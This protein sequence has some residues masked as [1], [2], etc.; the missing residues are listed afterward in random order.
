[1]NQ[2]E[3][4][5]ATR[6]QE[7]AQWYRVASLR[8]RVQA[9]ARLHRHRYR[10]ALWYVLEDRA[11]GQLHRFTP[12]ARLLIAAM[13]GRRSMDDLWRLGQTQL[14]DDA[15]TQDE[16]INLVA[17][18]HM[19][20]VLATDIPPDTLES[21]ERGATSARR[22][23]RS[24]W[25]NPMAI[26][27]PLWDPGA[28]LDHHAGLWRLLWGRAGALLW[29]LLVVPAVLLVPGAWPELTG[30]L[31]DRV[32]Q[33]N[34]LV[35]MA[36]LF[37]L[38]KILHEIGHATAVRAHGGEVHDMGVM[39]LVLMPIP[40]VDASAASAFRSRWSRACVGA[41]GMG[42][43]ILLAALAFFLWLLVEPGL[44]RAVCFNVMLVA[45]ISTLLFNGNPL[46]RFDAYYIVADLLELPN[47]A[48]R[49]ARY[50]GYLAERYLLRNRRA[51]A[52]VESGSERAWL[53]SYGL[54][55]T[56]YR[57]FITFAIALFISTRF[58]FVGVILAL[59]AIAVMMLMP[60][61][62]ALNQVR[63]RPGLRERRGRI[64]ALGMMAASVLVAL[65]VWVPMPYRTQAEGVVWL[66]EE[67]TLRAG[68]AGFVH[69]LRAAP[70]TRVAAGAPLVD[71]IDPTL[72]ADLRIAEARVAE[73]QARYDKVFVSDRAQAQIIDEQLRF[74]RAALER[75]R[76]R[77][78]GLLAHA[79]RDG[80]F[81][82]ARPTDLPGRF[83]R[84]GEVLGYV[85]GDDDPVV[86]V[87]VEQ[88]EVDGVGVTARSVDLR[89]TDDIGRAIPGRIVRQ[90][91]AG[92][93]EVPSAALVAAGGG[94]LAADPRDPEGRRILTRVFEIDVAPIEPLGRTPAFGQRVYVRFDLAPTPLA[95][96][97]WRSLR[98]LF[99]RHFNV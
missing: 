41:A 25:M 64:A 6:P 59:W 21:F 97:A 62:R 30:N 87:V 14:G 90:V 39:L 37:P 74:E 33:A 1:M 84:Q 35:L 57:L 31:S 40:Y 80:R 24:A 83:H 88:A 98:R 94:R 70:G 46:L 61:V 12:G 10:D 71:S 47:L 44:V 52:P 42:V 78:A 51:E 38:V 49:S 45:G 68:A 36:L 53:F 16:L 13:D 29:L 27:V 8:P 76:E 72:A 55:S 60:L 32:L 54:A 85:I 96:Q 67:S 56:L 22:K 89:L 75:T 34:N 28:F 4:L 65:A 20:D 23:R 48:Q 26:R 15:P 81:T 91:P 43:E 11:T 9:R 86:R 50:W 77:A 2:G 95:T 99:L 5:A 69:R 79:P 93:D 18:L 3:P 66:P 58:F 82:V 7:S 73:L 92:S 63:E 19:A 17:Q